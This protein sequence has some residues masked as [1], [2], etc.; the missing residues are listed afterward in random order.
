MDTHRF[1]FPGFSLVRL[2]DT[3][4]HEVEV[5]RVTMG[6]E[7]FIVHMI[8]KRGLL[9]PNG[10]DFL[11]AKV[12]DGGEKNLLWQ[13]PKG[14]FD[15]FGLLAKAG[16][17]TVVALVR[18]GRGGAVEEVIPFST[19]LHSPVELHRK[20]RLKMQAAEFL[21]RDYVL[22]TAERIIIERDDERRKEEDRRREEEK[23][24]ARQ[25]AFEARRRAR[26]ELTSRVQARSRLEVFTADGQRRSGF[27]VTGTEWLSLPDGTFVVLVESYD[28]ETGE[29]GTPIEAFRTVKKEG[30]NPA[31]GSSAP[32]LLKR[33]ERAVKPVL[34]VVKTIVIETADG[35]FEVAVYATME[36]IRRAREAGLNS[37][38]LVTAEDRAHSDG[39]F[40]VFSV[41]D[42]MKTIGIFAPIA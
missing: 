16:D 18:K 21:G 39:R 20:V 17:E 37:G 36:N 5:G 6:D 42:G 1:S 11:L 31:K 9:L 34:A 25:S 12:F 27:P 41:C 22:S 24:A 40:E 23:R 35:A 14:S 26:E 8:R 19:L 38:A 2:A 4:T 7:V 33:P 30:K 28:E 10:G 32:V 3:W 15:G 13:F 29:V